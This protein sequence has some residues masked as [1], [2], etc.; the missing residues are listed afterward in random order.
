MWLCVCIVVIA[1]RFTCA[2]HVHNSI[3]RNAGMQ[4]CEGESIR[5]QKSREHKGSTRS[6]ERETLERKKAPTILLS[7]PFTDFPLYFF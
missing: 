4:G 5:G 7:F 3:S 1:C 6:S 2:V